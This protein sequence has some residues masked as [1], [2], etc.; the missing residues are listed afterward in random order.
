VIDA[1][2]A[3]ADGLHELLR[4]DGWRVARAYDGI[5]GLRLAASLRPDVVFCDLQLG[6]PPDAHEVARALRASLSEK[7]IHLVG[8]TTAHLRD[9]PQDRSATGFDEILQ[10]PVHFKQIEAILASL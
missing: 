3:L 5:E 7:P 6:G 1:Y 2:R 9:C 4:H 10:K 8:L